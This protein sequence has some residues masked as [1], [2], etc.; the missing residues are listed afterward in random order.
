MHPGQPLEGRASLVGWSTAGAR[1]QFVEQPEQRDELRRLPVGEG[2]ERPRDCRRHADG[3]V[4][5]LVG[6]MLG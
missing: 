1:R 5:G 2:G 6:K 4:F 3:V